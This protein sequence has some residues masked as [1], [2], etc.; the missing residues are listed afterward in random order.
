ME[1]LRVIIALLFFLCGVYLVVTAITSADWF[2]LF[3]SLGA[4]LAAY[5]IWP[6]KKRGKRDDSNQ[7]LDILEIIIELPIEILLWLFRLGARLFK[8]S[9]PGIDL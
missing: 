5:F 9:D 3:F 6:S 4:F 2:L 8:D 1:V 7:W